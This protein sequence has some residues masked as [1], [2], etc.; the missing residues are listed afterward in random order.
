M[1]AVDECRRQARIQ[2]KRPIAIRDRSAVVPFTEARIGTVRMGVGIVRPERDGAVVMNDRPVQ[3]PLLLVCRAEIVVGDRVFGVALERGIE[4]RDR[5]RDLSSATVID[6]YVH[7]GLGIARL[8]FG[9]FPPVHYGAPALVHLGPG[10]AAEVVEIG[11]IGPQRQRMV[12]I[13][14]R[15]G[16]EVVVVQEQHRHLPAAMRLIPQAHQ[17]GGERGGV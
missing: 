17:R 7:I 14:D 6:A 5:L 16:G 3:I 13:A 15:L 1:A 4:G 2:L 8:E 10:D 12:E 11:I 9:G